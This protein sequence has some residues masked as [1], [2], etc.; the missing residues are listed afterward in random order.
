[1]AQFTDY[2]KTIKKRLIDIDRSQTWLCRE[3][4]ERTGRYFDDS[5]L[6]KICRGK[7]VPFMD[8]AVSAINDI[9]GL[10]GGA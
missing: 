10:E 8:S 7:T 5:Y 3:V 9:L 1:L 6:S 2:G 4:G